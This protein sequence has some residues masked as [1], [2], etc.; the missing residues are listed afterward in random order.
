LVD[1]RGEDLL[2]GHP[3]DPQAVGRISLPD[4]EG[5]MCGGRQVDGSS[6][7]LGASRPITYGPVG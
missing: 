7:P 2:S 3:R 6:C 5:S 4:V 1:E